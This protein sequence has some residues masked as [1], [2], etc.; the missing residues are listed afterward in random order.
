MSDAIRR[1]RDEEGRVWRAI[2]VQSGGI[3]FEANTR[4]STSSTLV[5]RPEDA[6]GPRFD[7]PVGREIWRAA[8]FSEEQLRA[9]LALARELRSE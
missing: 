6:D 8:Q 7:V 5:L 9:Q 2:I 4:P 3:T 1:F